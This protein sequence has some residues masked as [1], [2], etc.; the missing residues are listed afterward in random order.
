[1]T[2][3]MMNGDLLNLL[4]RSQEQFNDKG[5]LIRAALPLSRDLKFFLCKS[6]YEACYYLWS[7]DRKVHN[8]LKLENILLSNDL[9]RV[10][11]CDF[12]ITTKFS[13]ILKF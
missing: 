10:M 13:K 3:A 7:T 12:G 11:L 9:S 2:E 1:M 6:V 4:K 8:D 5:E